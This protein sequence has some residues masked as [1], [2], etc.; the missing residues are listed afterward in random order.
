[1][2]NKMRLYQHLAQCPV[3]LRVFLDYNPIYWCFVPFLWEDALAESI[4]YLPGATTT[5]PDLVKM[6][7]N[8]VC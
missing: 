2:A 3:A 4:A 5:D 1:M 7:P 6:I 8:R